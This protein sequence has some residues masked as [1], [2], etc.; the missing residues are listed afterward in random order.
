LNQ[1]GSSL[2]FVDLVRSIVER[3]KTRLSSSASYCDDY[4]TWIDS[5]G[6]WNEHS[7]YGTLLSSFDPQFYVGGDNDWP[8]AGHGIGQLIFGLNLLRPFLTLVL[9]PG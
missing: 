9:V 1:E 8:F 6:L 2:D 4:S 5:F 3:V 7:I